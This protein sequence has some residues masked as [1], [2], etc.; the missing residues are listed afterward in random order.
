M[1]KPWH[2]MQIERK[3]AWR[4]QILALVWTRGTLMASLPF[5]CTPA[6]PEKRLRLT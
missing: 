4:G 2:L 6:A 3:W 5:R 1:R